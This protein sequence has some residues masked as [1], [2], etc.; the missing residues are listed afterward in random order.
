MLRKLSL[1]AA[2]LVVIPFAVIPCWIAA[3]RADLPYVDDD[4]LA[5]PLSVIDPEGNGVGLLTAAAA[6][7]EW[8]EAKESDAR[9]RAIRTGTMWEPDW[10]RTR[11]DRNAAALESLKRALDA[12]G[13][14]FRSYRDAGDE[15]IDVLVAAQ[16]LVRLAGAEA[17]LLLA[18][19]ETSAA[20]DRAMLGMRL[21]KRIA[22]GERGELVVMM[23]AV[24]T[25]SL[26]LADLE[27][28]V[29]EA[30]LSEEAARDLID[31]LD[32]ERW[33]AE[34]WARTWAAEYH[35]ARALLAELRSHDPLE[36]AG[37]DESTW[38][39]VSSVVPADYLWQ[40]NRTLTAFAE[41]YRERQQRS[42]ATCE[43]AAGE[44]ERGGRSGLDVARLLVAPNPYGR[45][46]IEV[47]T[48]NFD[49]FDLKRCHLETRI[50]LLQLLVAAKA[51][52]HA[53]GELPGRPEELVPRYFDRVPVDRFGGSALRYSAAEQ[54][55]WS[56][57]EDFVE[58]REAGD[59]DPNDIAEPAISLAF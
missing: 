34:D 44:P 5:L 3:H 55:A 7:L 24:A 48:P 26:S 27:V 32:A 39:W 33:V 56:V 25:Q 14:Q 2:A 8:P 49:R 19:G 4:D 58:G 20:I 1:I 50:A 46:L 17:R 41:R 45:I 13:F 10:I 21:G 29:R 9:L 31:R 51:H 40:P 18:S 57:G 36:A 42:G 59:P 30:S 37:P 28:V 47:A 16:R 38:G 6:L 15:Q 35:Y 43:R 53:T 52:W 23:F 12:P 54:V 11:V 22:G